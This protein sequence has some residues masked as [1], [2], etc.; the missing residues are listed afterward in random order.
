MNKKLIFLDI[1]GTL[2]MPG[3]SI[4]PE[5]VEGLDKARENGHYIFINTGRTDKDI[6]DHIKKVNWNGGVYSAGGKIIVNRDTIYNNTLSKEEVKEIKDLFDDLD[7]N[8]IFE[9]ANYNYASREDPYGFDAQLQSL[10]NS[11]TELQRFT[12]ANSGLTIPKNIEEYT[13]EDPVYKINF[14]FTQNEKDKLKK[15]KDT[16]GDR[17]RIDIFSNAFGEE[18]TMGEMTKYEINKGAGIKALS[19]YYDIPM[20]DTIA[21]GDSENDLD[22]IRAAGTGFAMGNANSNIKE[23]ADIVCDTC[24]NNGVIKALEELKII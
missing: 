7:I 16:F 20:E 11:S 24:E 5:T 15:V 6:P 18:F 2:A 8:Y 3:N 10:E 1:D 14:R 21:F 13:F 19:D 17:F 23:E 22:M 12:K 4:S 9:G